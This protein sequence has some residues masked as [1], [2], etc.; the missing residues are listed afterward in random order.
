MHCDAKDI[1]VM[2]ETQMQT[3]WY[4]QKVCEEHKPNSILASASHYNAEGLMA[5]FVL[6]KNQ[7]ITKEAFCP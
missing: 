4:I 5:L 7:H 2:A 1:P 3:H 6:L